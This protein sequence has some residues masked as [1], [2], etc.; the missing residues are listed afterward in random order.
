MPLIIRFQDIYQLKNYWKNYC[1]KS[2][3]IVIPWALVCLNPAM[4][5]RLN[6]RPAIGHGKSFVQSAYI[7]I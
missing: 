6:T 2:F 5:T 1:A 7:H 3:E 4:Q